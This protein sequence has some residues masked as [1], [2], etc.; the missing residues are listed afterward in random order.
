MKSLL[1]TLLLFF[2]CSLSFG[3]LPNGYWTGIQTQVQLGTAPFSSGQGASSE[4]FLRYGIGWRSMQPLPMKMRFNW[5]SFRSTVDIGL[6]YGLSATWQG[7]GYEVP[8]GNN[9]FE[10]FALEAPIELQFT[11]QNFLHRSIRK[12]PLKRFVRVGMRFSYTFPSSQTSGQGNPG[13]PGY[14]TDD[15][16][17]GGR[18]N[19]MMTFG[20]GVQYQKDDANLSAVWF[21]GQFGFSNS[22]T[23]DLSYEYE[24]NTFHVPYSYQGT[25]FSLNAL[26]LFR[27]RDIPTADE[28]PPIIFCPEL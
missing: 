26:Y 16:R 1:L 4:G 28:I 5:A 21:S 13:T 7:V 17:I 18:L 10:F 11:P 3:Q 12:K 8:G 22:L 20:A 15:T 24:G 2:C 27:F 14:Y 19:P 23:G 9:S 6:H 25:Y